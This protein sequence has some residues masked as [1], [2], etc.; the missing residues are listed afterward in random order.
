MSITII[1]SVNNNYRYYK[2]NVMQNDFH[3]SFPNTAIEF[4]LKKNQINK[5]PIYK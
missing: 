5:L 1:A 3:F 2:E 4:S